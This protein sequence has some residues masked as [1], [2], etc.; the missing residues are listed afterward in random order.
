MPEM[1]EAAEDHE[2]VEAGVSGAVEGGDD[3]DVSDDDNDIDDVGGINDLGA[4]A[5]SRTSVALVAGAEEHIMDD[6]DDEDDE[7]VE[8]RS[9]EAEWAGT[10]TV[11]GLLLTAVVDTR[12]AG[13]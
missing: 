8:D 4:F 9:A 2:G 12:A 5:V 13:P 3:A 6:D 1:E 11:R 10:T 7:A